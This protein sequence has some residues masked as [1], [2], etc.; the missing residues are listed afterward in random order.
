[1]EAQTAHAITLM[2]KCIMQIQLAQ[3]RQFQAHSFDD[4]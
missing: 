4:V 1:M 3:P 2:V